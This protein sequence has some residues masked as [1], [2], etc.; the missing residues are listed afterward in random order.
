MFG[1][2]EVFIADV[3]ILQVVIHA[4]LILNTPIDSD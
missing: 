3:I 2:F 4:N 1:I